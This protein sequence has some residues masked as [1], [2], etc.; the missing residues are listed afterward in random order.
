MLKDE[1]LPELPD[2]EPLLLLEP[3]VFPKLT[4]S[5]PPLDTK[6]AKESKELPSTPVALLIVAGAKALTDEALVAVTVLVEL[7]PLLVPVLFLELEALLELETFPVLFLEL[8]LE[9]FLELELLL[10]LELFLELLEPPDFEIF[11]IFIHSL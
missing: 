1:L 8:E 11:T 9:L 5:E 7:E 10:E 6:D 2:E 4:L 3:D